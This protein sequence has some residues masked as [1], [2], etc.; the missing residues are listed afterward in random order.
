MSNKKKNGGA[1]AGRFTGLL[2][3]LVVVV[4]VILIVRGVEAK[5][6]NAEPETSTPVESV[7]PDVVESED[8]GETESPEPSPSEEPSPEPSPS[9]EPSPEPSATPEISA[10][11]SFTSDTGTGLNVVADWTAAST[12]DGN[13]LFTV[14]LS[15]LS[16]TLHVNEI[17]AGAVITIGDQSFTIKTDA[18]D[19]DS[20][21]AIVETEVASAQ[22]TLTLGSDGTLS[23][24]VT[25]TWNFKGTY[26]DQEFESVGAAG[27]ADI[28]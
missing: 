26:S 3:I 2:F 21:S 24:P 27:T 22:T 23:V 5:K 10:S 20:N 8:P 16:Y 1:F 17:P 25:A 28:S 6:N 19:C 14:K 13:V 4:V 7:S 12:D 15:V 9:E 11:G 18:I